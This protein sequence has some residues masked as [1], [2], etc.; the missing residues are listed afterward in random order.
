MEEYELANRFF[1]SLFILVYVIH[2]IVENIYNRIEMENNGKEYCFEENDI[3][4]N[5]MVFIKV[6]YIIISFT[7]LFCDPDIIF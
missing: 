2:F 3:Y 1:F 4:F 6:S 5:F 7:I